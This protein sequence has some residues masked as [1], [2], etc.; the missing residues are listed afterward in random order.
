MPPKRRR[1]FHGLYY[2]SSPP[3]VMPMNGQA[4]GPNGVKRR[5]NDDFSVKLSTIRIWIHEKD[6]A[7]L[8]RILW[9]GQGQRLCQQASNNGRV[10]RFLAAVPHVMN[11]S[12]DLHQA[13]IDN[14]LETLQSQLEP[15]VPAA[16]VTAKDG[17]G[18]NVIHKA[19][20]L[21]HTKILE[22]L[23]GLWPEGAHEIDIT[24]KTPLHWA[25]SAKNNMRCYTLLT[26]AGCDEEALDYKMKTPVYYRHKPH[27]IE[28][29]FLVYVPEAPRISPDSV[30][31]WEALSDEG[32]DS[33]V[34]G[35]A[36]RS[37]SKQSKKLNIK[38]TAAVNGRKS[39][40]DSAENTSELDTNDG[41]SANEDDDLSKAD[42]EVE[43]L[44]SQQRRPETP[45]A[46]A[47]AG[48]ASDAAD[49]G[50]TES[51][52][53]NIARA[54][55]DDDKIEAEPAAEENPTEAEAE[56]ETET[57]TEMEN[58]TATEEA[59]ETNGLNEI[60]DNVDDVDAESEQNATEKTEAIENDVETVAEAEPEPESE[61]EPEI[62][63][64][65]QAETEAEVQLTNG[66]VA[67]E[68]VE[69]EKTADDEDE[70]DDDEDVI[71]PTPSGS[72]QQEQQQAKQQEQQ[73]AE[74]DQDL[75]PDNDGGDSLTSSL[76]IEGF[77]QGASEDYTD[78]RLQEI[79]ESGDMEQ[80][81]EIVLNG[82]GGRLLS[83]KSK[84]PEIQAFL[85]NVP[86]YMEKIHRVHDAARDG[87]LLA[88]Q[89]ALDRRKFAIAKNDI[90]PNGATPLHV[91]VLFGHS[92]IVR[93]LASR[94]PETMEI[95]DND[96]RTALHYAATIKDNGH[97]YNVLSQLGANPK[98]VD[99][100]GHTP[101]FYV[102]MDKSKDVLT[103]SEL[104]TIF[105]AEEM[106]NQLLSDQGQAQPVSFQANPI[107]KTEQGKYLAD[108]L[109][110]PL[111]KALTEIANKRPKDPVAYLANYLQHFMDERKPITEAEVHSGSSSKTSSN[112]TAL[113]SSN[114]KMNG[115]RIANNR[116]QL[117]EL[118]ARSLVEQQQLQEEDDDEDGALA[119]QHME[120]RDEHGQ[121]MLHFACARSHRRGALYTL[122]EESRIDITYRDELYRTARDVALQANQP[123]NAAEI[124]RFLLA[125]A[126]VGDVDSFEQLAL[127]GYDHILDIED[128]SGK[129]ILDVAGE[130]QNEALVNFLNNLRAMEE[131]REELHQMIRDKNL[132]RIKEL[133]AVPNAK[134]LIR[135]KNYYGRTALHI[136]VLKESEEM[137]QHLVQLCP[138]ALKVTD[139]L[140][141][142][143][144]HY[145][146][147]TNFCETVS[148]ILIQNGAKRTAKDLKGR[149]P[150]YYFIN[151]ADILRLQEEEEE[152]R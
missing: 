102:D 35:D 150:S 147:G 125:Q 85:N 2:H 143:V 83:L 71:A 132:V 94:F 59:E 116:P 115:N 84:E 103:Y 37:S 109:A 56:A 24:G 113:A 26:Q 44:P 91:A 140:E 51:E 96:G 144:L 120:E 49:A 8:T 58:G 141:R 65:K 27:E 21:G 97:F 57:E 114:S 12:K 93:Y 89:Q 92:D 104:L 32:N 7:K 77:V 100:L 87:S 122:I 45:A 152:S 60:D 133:T 1:R 80:L 101:E 131:A 127:Q 10:K 62:E 70:E 79:I 40:D 68:N 74:L 28:R 15:P 69:P 36:S 151:K 63:K 6:I 137:V 5:E 107:F 86:S 126:V 111:I 99:K 54:V 76:A 38:P 149:Q 48:D 39:L 82:E 142:T 67:G 75:V 29:A 106:E 118:D 17:N 19:A 31:D 9:A 123:N 90:S 130:R 16:L 129:T 117:V 136:A 72:Q 81:A 22:Y 14:N 88:L 64:E 23:I 108:T 112:S 53:E 146:L 128:E 110:D 73:P 145:A 52:A 61:P 33:S 139:N 50:D 42:A 134:W 78:A 66:D 105:G 43:P 98:A 3:K 138:E 135:T 119:V 41:T 47:A 121:S 34:G 95:T 20:G 13:V 55:S 30:T 25:A 11:A 124:D 18:L 4:A 148:R 46:L